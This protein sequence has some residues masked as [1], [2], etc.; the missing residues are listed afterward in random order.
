MSRREHVTLEGTPPFAMVPGWVARDPDCTRPMLA[1]YVELALRCTFQERLVVVHWSTLTEAMGCGRSQV[2]GHLAALR[3]IG[4]LIERDDGSMLLPMHPPDRPADPDPSGLAG[5][6][7]PADP[8]EASGLAGPPP[9]PTEGS[10]SLL[11]SVVGSAGASDVEVVP[12][13][14]EVPRGG[15]G[16]RLVDRFNLSPAM[17]EWAAAETPG[18]DVRRET[19]RFADY[20]RGIA[21]ARGR[22]VDWLATWRNWMR[23]AQDR[24]PRSNGRQTKTERVL[25]QHPGAAAVIAEHLLP[26]PQ[27]G[28]P[29]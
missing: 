7:R 23:T 4:A 13:L 21:G 5:P 18:V 8:D 26:N 25:E 29:R 2:M 9:L 27:R 14:D 11:P 22:K 1:L 19:A 6:D 12:F 15:R 16:T 17:L 24:L 20:W 10:D 28:L 3:K